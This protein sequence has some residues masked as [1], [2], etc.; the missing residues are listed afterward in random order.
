M[1]P[2]Q[3]V[4]PGP[5][6]GSTRFG[7]GSAPILATVL[8]DWLPSAEI[9]P[10]PPVMPKLAR[11]APGGLNRNVFG[12]VVTPAAHAADERET[13]VSG[14]ADRG[15]CHA[16]HRYAS[17][18]HCAHSAGLCGVTGRAGR[19]DNAACR[20]ACISLSDARCSSM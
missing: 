12:P 14:D 1:S 19:R 16:S 9:D 11:S 6:A 7:V 2:R 5:A 4:K 13:R 8:I 18:A 10:V 17:S 20:D 15:V 3:Q